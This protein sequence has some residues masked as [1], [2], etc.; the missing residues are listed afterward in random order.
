M[1]TNPTI[2]TLAKVIEEVKKQDWGHKWKLETPSEYSYFVCRNC[3][4]RIA[5]NGILIGICTTLIARAQQAAVAKA[6]RWARVKASACILY[7]FYD[8]D[9]RL[10]E[11]A[12]A[13]EK[14]LE[15]GTK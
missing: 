8:F 11:T 15:D 3:N 2:P 12:G 10:E 4:E 13:I 9:S 14:E 1:P 5:P 6:L 7:D